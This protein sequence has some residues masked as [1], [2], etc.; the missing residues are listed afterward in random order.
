MANRSAD[1]EIVREPG[2]S[3]GRLSIVAYR[4]G[5]PIGT[6]EYAAG[7]AWGTWYIRACGAETRYRHDRAKTFEENLSAVELTL[8]LQISAATPRLQSEMERFALAGAF[9]NL[10]IAS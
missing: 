10:E 2:M 4:A 5:A 7:N 8:R 1:I 6:A 9:S 3:A